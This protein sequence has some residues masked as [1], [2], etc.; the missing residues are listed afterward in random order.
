MLTEFPAFTSSYNTT[1]FGYAYGVD[2]FWRDNVS[3]KNFEYGVSYSYLD[4]E[5][6]YRNFPEKR[7][8]FLH[9]NMIF[10]W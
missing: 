5:R 8:L 2:L 4:K 9:Q 1:G 7:A 3:F 6:D 10:L